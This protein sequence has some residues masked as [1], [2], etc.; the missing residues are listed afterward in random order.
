M[1]QAFM[2]CKGCGNE[3]NY[4]GLSCKTAICPKCS[5]VNRLQFQAIRIT[6]HSGIPY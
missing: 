5:V 1:A 6:S 4:S 3:W 2:Q